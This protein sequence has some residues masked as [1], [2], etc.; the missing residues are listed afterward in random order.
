MQ[1][2]GKSE[3][4]KQQPTYRNIAHLPVRLVKLTVT[5]LHA[6]LLLAETGR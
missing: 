6:V 2:N 4:A 3:Q 5:L 1:E